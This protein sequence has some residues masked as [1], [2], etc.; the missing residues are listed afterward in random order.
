[1]ELHYLIEGK[2]KVKT[3]IEG[4]FETISVPGEGKVMSFVTDEGKTF[5][6]D[7]SKENFVR[8]EKW[9]QFRTSADIQ[10]TGKKMKIGKHF[11]PTIRIR[12]NLAGPL[13][14]KKR[15]DFEDEITD[16]PIY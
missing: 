9:D 1:M 4:K 12:A 5:I 11:Y 10:K 8:F 7:A 13:D 16:E 14:K 3:G 6:I 15:K 2:R